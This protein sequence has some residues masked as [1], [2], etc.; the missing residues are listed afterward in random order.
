MRFLIEEAINCAKVCT[1][2]Q[3]RDQLIGGLIELA[4]NIDPTL[5]QSYASSFES[6]D[7]LIN[8]SDK[9]TTLT[10][11]SDPKKIDSFQKEQTDRI[12]LDFLNR[13]FK[14]ICSGKGTVY[15][16]DIVGKWINSTVGHDFETILL[17]IS[18]YVENKIAGNNKKSKESELGELFIGI[19]QLLEFIRNV[20]TSIYEQTASLQLDSFYKILTEPNLLTFGLNEQ[21]EA[22]LSIKKWISENTKDN[23]IIYDP[24]FNEEMLNLF[25]DIYLDTRIIIYSSIRTSEI[26]NIEP[27]YRNFW[28]RIC[29]HVPPQTNINLYHTQS[30]E[31]PLR[32]RYILSDYS[33]LSIGTSINGLGSK[34]STIKYLDT[35]EKDKIEKEIIMP[36]TFRPPTTY[37]NQK[38]YTKT[39]SL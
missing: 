17:G 26:E 25:K 20:E 5:A 16:D 6:S 10:L 38:L 9:L 1:H 31:T 35:A 21:E 36:L 28:G 39:F 19:G 18:W 15:H 13:V 30:G 4:H 32:D 27:R 7:S 34:F 37:K 22:F 2:V 8:L 24:Y 29:D 12:L 33:G 11:H 23:L 3:G 14:S